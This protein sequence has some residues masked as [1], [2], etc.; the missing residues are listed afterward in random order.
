M[1]IRTI[2]NIAPLFLW[3]E[4]QHCSMSVLKP[5]PRITFQYLPIP[6]DE[7]VVLV[8]PNNRRLSVLGQDL[9]GWL[10]LYFRSPGS[11]AKEIREL[12]DDHAEEIYPYALRA[13]VRYDD[14]PGSRFLVKLLLERGLLVRMLSAPAVS[15]ERIRSVIQGLLKEN[16]DSDVDLAKAV[17]KEAR[18]DG[19]ER[20]GVLRLLNHLEQLAEAKRISARL[21]P[22]LRH[23]DEHIRSKVVRIVGK[24]GRSSRWLARRLTDSDPRTR[25]NAIEALWGIDDDLSRGLLENA[26]QDDHQRVVGNALVGLYRI[27]DCRSIRELAAMGSHDSPLFRAAAAWAMGETRDPRF[28]TLL[29]G[30]SRDGD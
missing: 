5:S 24:C 22:L 3:P 25:A 23:L 14:S 19:H 17:V 13:I 4:G 16:P 10:R 18:R 1:P 28:K 2:S 27:G 20:K 26:L 15:D 12:L 7:R 11:A 29:G 8:A 30:L 9:N 6:A 21:L